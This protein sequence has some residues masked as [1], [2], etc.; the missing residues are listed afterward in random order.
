[1]PIHDWTRVSA[2]TFHD[3]H[4]AWI[5]ELRKVLNNGLLPAGFYA[6]SEQV[7]GDAN[8]DVLTLERGGARSGQR[9]RRRGD[10]RARCSPAG[11]SD[12]TRL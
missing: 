11:R 7:S 2:G 10:V 4:V 5:A 1:M 9:I 6:M 8:V 12:R 3:F